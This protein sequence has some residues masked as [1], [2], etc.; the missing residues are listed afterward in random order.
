[1]KLGFRFEEV[2]FGLLK[3]LST[4]DTHVEKTAQYLAIQRAQ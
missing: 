3:S 2:I 4:R 1:M